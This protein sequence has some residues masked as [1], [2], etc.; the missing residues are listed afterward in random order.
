LKEEDVLRNKLLLEVCQDDTEMQEKLKQ[1]FLDD[2]K[3]HEDR[4]V[5]K[6]LQDKIQMR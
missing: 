1:R 4:L 2:W 5:T 3:K 6:R